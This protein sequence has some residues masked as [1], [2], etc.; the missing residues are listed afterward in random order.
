M[1]GVCD[2]LPVVVLD[3]VELLRREALALLFGNQNECHAW[4]FPVGRA[5]AG[6]LGRMVRRLGLSAMSW[7]KRF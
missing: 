2:D 1:V 3:L 5:E 6:G 4:M 7:W